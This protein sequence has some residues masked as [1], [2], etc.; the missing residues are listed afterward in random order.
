MLELHDC[1][2]VRVR[3]AS[4]E[5]ET[6][7][8][9]VATIAATLLLGAPGQADQAKRW[10]FTPVVPVVPPAVT[11]TNWVSN[12]IDAFILSRLEA[13]GIDVVGI[14]NHTIFKSIYFFDPNGH[15]IELATN[16]NTPK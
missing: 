3:L 12:P 14:T 6:T 8:R 1:N 11:N 16:A 10:P 2:R 7:M 13:N 5:A 4:V 15:R 9:F